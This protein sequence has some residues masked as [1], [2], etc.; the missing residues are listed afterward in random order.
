M[1][2]EFQDFAEAVLEHFFQSVWFRLKDAEERTSATTHSCV[3]SALLV[4]FLLDFG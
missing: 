2:L 3:F 4:E 1:L